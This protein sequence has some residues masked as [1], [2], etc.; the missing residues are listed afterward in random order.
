MKKAFFTVFEGLSIDENIK[1][2]AKF[3]NKIYCNNFIET[4][5]KIANYCLGNPFDYV[6]NYF[7]YLLIFLI[8]IS[9]YSFCKPMW[10]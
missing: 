5:W 1:K 6:I 3:L 7:L 4:E 9:N 8:P 10:K 2:W